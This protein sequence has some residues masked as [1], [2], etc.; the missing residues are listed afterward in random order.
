[1]EHKPFALL[2][3][4]VIFLPSPS[5]GHVQSY[6]N[7]FQKLHADAAFCQQAFGEY[8]KAREWTDDEVKDVVFRD[9]ESRWGSRGMG[10]L[11]MGIVQE[12][13]K[14]KLPTTRRQLSIAGHDVAA[15]EGDEFQ[16]LWNDS[17]FFENVKWAG[18]V[19]VR[20]AK[21]YLEKSFVERYPAGEMPPWQELIEVRYGLDAEFRGKGLVTT[22]MQ[23]VM[24]WAVAERDAKRFIGETERHNAKSASVLRRLGLEVA[25]THYFEDDEVEWESKLY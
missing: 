11:A 14:A 5:S 12:P 9:A 21:S 18:Y 24:A 4:D 1:M 8:F 6:R 19:C 15:I 13:F 16:R 3:G 22:G 25:D 23:I 10:D 2:S 7:L 17:E 20:D